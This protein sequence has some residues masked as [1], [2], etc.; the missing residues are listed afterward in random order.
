MIVEQIYNN[1]GSTETKATD[2]TDS[3]R[4]GGGLNFMLGSHITGG[5]RAGLITGRDDWEESYVAGNISI[6]F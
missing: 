2:Y 4:I 5:V 6:G 1:D 3:I